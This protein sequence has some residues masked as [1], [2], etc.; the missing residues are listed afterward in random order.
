M[1]R[2]RG[3]R[4]NVLPVVPSVLAKGAAARTQ[5]ES[6]G[7]GRGSRICDQNQPR[8][9]PRHSCR[10]SHI[11]QYRCFGKIQP[12]LLPCTNKAAAI[13]KWAKDVREYGGTRKGKVLPKAFCFSQ[14][15]RDAQVDGWYAV[16]L[17][18]ST[19]CL[20]SILRRM[21]GFGWLCS[22]F[23][24]IILVQVISCGRLRDS[25]NALEGRL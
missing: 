13:L 21:D 6:R 10:H 15:S 19:L 5:R 22:R 2:V 14:V 24:M 23:P 25:T 9:E 7:E 20:L 18:W 4:Q 11:P 17:E 8:T 3:F 12:N 16:H 1:K